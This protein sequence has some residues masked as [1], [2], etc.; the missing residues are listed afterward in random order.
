[1]AEAE[2]ERETDRHLINRQGDRDRLKQRERQIDSDRERE[3][4]TCKDS[5]R[6]RE[7]DKR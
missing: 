7:R 6:E 3:R 5:E 2:K 4:D 1:M